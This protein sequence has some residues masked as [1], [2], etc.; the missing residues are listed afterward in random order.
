[1]SSEKR[2]RK[3]SVLNC[4]ITNASFFSLSLCSCYFARAFLPISSFSIVFLVRPWWPTLIL[5]LYTVRGFAIDRDHVSHACETCLL[6]VDAFLFCHLSV[7]FYVMQNQARIRSIRKIFFQIWFKT[8]RGFRPKIECVAFA[9]SHA[10]L[11]SSVNSR[12]AS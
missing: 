1:M 4:V 12:R 2:P 6:R 10:S 8:P 7:S 5:F 3:W 9:N 11:F